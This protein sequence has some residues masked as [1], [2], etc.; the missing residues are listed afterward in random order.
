ME[1]STKAV[2]SGGGLADA[3]AVRLAGRRATGFLPQGDGPRYRVVDAKEDARP[4]LQHQ[5]GASSGTNQSTDDILTLGARWKRC[6]LCVLAV[7][8]VTGIIPLAAAELVADVL[9]GVIMSLESLIGSG[10]MA[11]LGIGACII[12]IIACMAYLFRLVIAR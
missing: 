1:T 5:A 11:A 9:T 6:G 10:T 7:G 4:V 3:G 8:T 12:A 2:G